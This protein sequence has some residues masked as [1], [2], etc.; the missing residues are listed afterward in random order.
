MGVK[1]KQHTYLSGSPDVYGVDVSSSSTRPEPIVDVGT[2]E[3]QV[4]LR[5]TNL[6]TTGDFGYDDSRDWAELFPTIPTLIGALNLMPEVLE[7]RTPA[8]RERLAEL[9]D[10]KFEEQFSEHER[11]LFARVLEPNRGM[12]A[13]YQ[14]FLESRRLKRESAALQRQNEELV[15]ERGSA[16]RATDDWMERFSRARKLDGERAERLLKLDYNPDLAPTAKKMLRSWR[17]FDG[18]SSRLRQGV[19][20]YIDGDGSSSYNRLRGL[21]EGWLDSFEQLKAAVKAPNPKRVEEK[22]TQDTTED[23]YNED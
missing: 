23:I 6:A 14:L 7:G 18:A 10:A 22:P 19:L 5:L 3:G 13:T 12:S 21:S 16:Y 1:T 4:I 20:A 11:N 9:F 15:A 17:D 8:E 2:D